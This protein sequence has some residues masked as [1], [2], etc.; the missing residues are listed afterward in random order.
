MLEIKKLGIKGTGKIDKRWNKEQTASF[1]IFECP[2]CKEHF[3]IK[4][5]IGI[6]R[7]TCIKCRGTQNETHGMSKTRLYDIWQ[8]M[9]DRCT[10]LN[11]KK[12]H[13]Y[14]GKGITVDPKWKTFEGFL[15]DMKE[16]YSDLL[17]IDRIDSSKGY[18]KDNCRWLSKG[19]NS[20]LT[21]RRRA[22]LQYRIILKPT[23]QLELVKQW[24]TILSAANELG[25]VASHI[26]FVCSGKRKSHGGF[27]WKYLED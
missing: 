15:E 8:Q 20:S 26:S 11:N 21:S 12:Y 10:N 5:Y 7:N 18:Y 17:T 9:W 6:K 4:T 16:G 24:D 14:G 2:V 27:V 3:E 22:V 25:L 1:S 23:K 19:E 13:I